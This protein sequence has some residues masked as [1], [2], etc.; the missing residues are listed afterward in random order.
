MMARRRSLLLVSVLCAVLVVGSVACRARGAALFRSE[1]CIDC[2]TFNG[3]G[4]RMG[5]DLT[6]VGERR[7]ELWMRQQ[8]RD[9]K[10]NNPRSRMPSFEHLSDFEIRSLVKYLND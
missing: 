3:V 2:H 6:A 1:G 9:S 5:P 8:I 7:T 4:G 10:V